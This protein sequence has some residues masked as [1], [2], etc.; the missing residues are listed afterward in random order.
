MGL[1]EEIR[2]LPMF[3]GSINYRSDGSDENI[4]IIKNKKNGPRVK[5]T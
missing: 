3:K 5:G 1:L 2:T 4:Q